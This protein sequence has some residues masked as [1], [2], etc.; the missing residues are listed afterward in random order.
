[1]SK[2]KIGIVGTGYIGNVHGR[3]FA[4]DE[5]VEVAALYD[6]ITERAEAA[7]KAIGG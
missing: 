4:S 6:I 2:L 3:I 5:R 7:S 1:M